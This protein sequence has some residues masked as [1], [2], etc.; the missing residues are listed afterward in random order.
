MATKTKPSGT[1][2]AKAGMDH[3]QQ[4]ANYMRSQA[5]RTGSEPVAAPGP[6]AEA[7][8]GK[9]RASALSPDD[10]KRANRE[11]KRTAKAGAGAAGAA[12]PEQEPMGDEVPVS[13]IDDTPRGR[14]RPDGDPAKEAHMTGKTSSGAATAGA[15]TKGAAKASTR[16][17]GE[18]EA[19]F[20]GRQRAEAET[21]LAT[22]AKAMTVEELADQLPVGSEIRIEG[23]GVSIRAAIAGGGIRTFGGATLHEAMAA[24][25]AEA[26]HGPQLLD[27]QPQSPDPAKT[28]EAEAEDASRKASVAPS[29]SG[30]SRAGAKKTG[31]K[32]ATKARR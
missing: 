27:D 6:D 19:Q 10:R 13:G 24:M 30:S 26:I 12:L 22:E 20:A 11:A 1:V 32:K 5:V 16:K 23:T 17:E 18:S 31:A 7:M 4:S 29:R 14:A 3:K 28:A 9:E 15:E 25:Q 21:K 8:S 2:P